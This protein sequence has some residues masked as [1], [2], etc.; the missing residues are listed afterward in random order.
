MSKSSQVQW[1]DRVLRPAPAH[2]AGGILVLSG[3]K[4]AQDSEPDPLGQLPWPLALSLP[5]LGLDLGRGRTISFGTVRTAELQSVS[6][7][8]ESCILAPAECGRGLD[9]LRLTLTCLRVAKVGFP[10]LPL[11]QH[12]EATTRRRLREWSISLPILFRFLPSGA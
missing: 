2:R 12:C 10:P 4:G 9:S 1:H 7:F 6:R 8:R 5:P 3:Q 11:L